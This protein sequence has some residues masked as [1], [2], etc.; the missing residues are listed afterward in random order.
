M[1]ILVSYAHIRSAPS[2]YDVIEGICDDV[3]VLMDSGAYTAY[4]QGAE[5][6]LE[7]YVAACKRLEAQLWDYIQLDVI[8]DKAKTA[9]NL[10]KM[11]DEGLTPM[12][13]LT[14]DED[15]AELP[16][17]MKVNKR[18]CVAGGVAHESVYYS[19]RIE[20]L[21]RASK[22]K[23]ELHGLGYTRGFEP[24]KSSVK[25][26]DSSSWMG[27]ARYG[28]F[29]FF[30]RM[31]GLPNIGYYKKLRKR[32]FIELPVALRD[33]FIRCGITC[34]EF[35]DPE[36][37]RGV[38][39]LLSFCGVHAWTQYARLCAEKGVRMFFAVPH[40]NWCPPLALMAHHDH[41]DRFDWKAI[42]SERDRVRELAKKDQRAFCD[43]WKEGLCRNIWNTS[44]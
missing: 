34:E 17:M 2:W 29:Q 24:L 35:A 27:N 18:V 23:A 1:N 25:S 38:L 41:G 7:E 8:K 36:L 20:R 19:A 43:Y 39:S 11:V 22:G 30:D 42:L 26:V 13:V 3:P 12:P 32:R 44:S 5:I 14:A 21:F 16:R 15:E 31:R 37:N 10:Q 40:K 9:F 4:T 28:N 6:T 33:Y